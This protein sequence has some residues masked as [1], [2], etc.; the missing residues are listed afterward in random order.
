MAKYVII[1]G[2]G[3]LG[4]HL[5]L[6]LVHEEKHEIYVLDKRPPAKALCAHVDGVKYQQVD[7]VDGRWDFPDGV[8]V[9]YDLAGYLG[10]VPCTQNMVRAV[11]ENVLTHAVVLDKLRAEE[12]SPVLVF[13]STDLVYGY[14]DVSSEVAVCEP[15]CGYAIMKRCA[16]RLFYLA[17]RVNDIPLVILR[18][19]TVYGPYQERLS[20]VN[21][22]IKAALCGADLTVFGNGTVLRDWL[23]VDDAVSALRLAPQLAGV[24]NVPGDPRWIRDVAE[25]V[26][27]IVGSGNVSQVPWP[28]L[29]ATVDVGDHVLDGSR[30]GRCGWRVTVDLEEGIRRTA[31]WMQSTKLA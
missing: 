12:R 15:I 19:S 3:F 29:T 22:F 2:G 7:I 21:L 4:L 31:E 8:D 27:E 10:S 20:L 28:T 5:V 30:I 11:R 1:G 6:A 23:Y 13:T 9:V 26:V 14:G 17:R 24:Y 18:L 25:T 16:E